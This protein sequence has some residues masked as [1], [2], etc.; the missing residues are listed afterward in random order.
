[1]TMPVYASPEQFM[2]DRSEYA[3]K[4]IGRGRSV[5]VTTYANGVLFVA[6][7]HSPTLH[8][9]SEIYD[10]IGLAAVEALYDAADDDSATAGPDLTRKI[11]PVVMTATADST[12]RLTEAEINAV[13]EAVVSG[14]M[15]NPGG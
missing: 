1:M 2:R 9:V 6:E 5:V 8:K 4:G 7:N 10:R 3:R 13:A 15:E 14:R 12:H 11:Y